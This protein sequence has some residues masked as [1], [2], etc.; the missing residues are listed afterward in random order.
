[1]IASLRPYTT[2]KGDPMAF[3]AL[4]DLEGQVDL[5]FFPRTW[6]ATRDQVAVDQVMLVIGTVQAGEDRLT[7]LVDTIRTNLDVASSMD[8]VL[9]P[10]RDEGPPEPAPDAAPATE[11]GRGR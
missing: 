8:S 7:I 11:A 5:V 1:M 6:Q 10:L 4:E 9:A 2:K 3:A